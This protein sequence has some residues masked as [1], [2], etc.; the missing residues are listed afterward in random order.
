MTLMLLD[1]SIPK[2]RVVNSIMNVG[3]EDL[4]KIPGTFNGHPT[5]N[6][7]PDSAAVQS[8]M[9]EDFYRQLRG[10]DL[11]PPPKNIDCRQADGTKLEVLGLGFV[12]MTLGPLILPGKVA[13]IIIRGLNSDVLLG[14]DFL[15]SR[16]VLIDFRRKCL[17]LF[18]TPV[19]FIAKE[20]TQSHRPAYAAYP[21]AHAMWNQPSAYPTPISVN[22]V[23]SQATG[24][25]PKRHIAEYVNWDEEYNEPDDV[26]NGRDPTPSPPQLEVP[27]THASTSEVSYGEA[28]VL[29]EPVEPIPSSSSQSTTIQ[30]QQDGKEVLRREVTVN[31][32]YRTGTQP[33]LVHQSA[34][35]TVNTPEGSTVIKVQA[36]KEPT[37]VQFR[38]S[39]SHIGAYHPKKKHPTKKPEEL[40]FVRVPATTTR[41]VLSNVCRS[42]EEHL[43]AGR[44]EKAPVDQA[45]KALQ[46]FYQVI[47]QEVFE[48]TPSSDDPEFIQQNWYTRYKIRNL[49]VP[50]VERGGLLS[51]LVLHLAT[52][53]RSLE[54]QDGSKLQIYVEYDGG[55][56]K[57]SVR[58]EPFQPTQEHINEWV[59]SCKRFGMVLGQLMAHLGFMRVHPEDVE[60]KKPI[61][62]QEKTQE[63]L[64]S[65]P[66]E[67][68]KII[69]L[70]PPFPGTPVRRP[71]HS[72]AD[73]RQE[74]EEH[75]T[76]HRKRALQKTSPP[77]EKG[78]Q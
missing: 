66:T 27:D 35:A 2:P 13:F 12:S 49:L 32:P 24:K 37:T 68:G 9:S 19:P 17:E 20:A 71:V 77:Q 25:R 57:I 67:R 51:E 33:V 74:G 53:W 43:L 59:T 73:Q 48:E 21:T 30:V 40:P 78:P 50:R 41:N 11:R 15:D 69:T 54:T 39:G 42:V 14:L 58:E 44:W 22:M 64:P 23:E 6:I 65:I 3:Q 75:R 47:N 72:V 26:Q 4:L 29:P 34:S 18:G 31:T 52:G 45:A 10:V 62:A 8:C 7:H 36:H 46:G 76:N 16:E 38:T 70:S 5:I 61:A 28:I 63:V 55:T 56:R 60:I 1:P